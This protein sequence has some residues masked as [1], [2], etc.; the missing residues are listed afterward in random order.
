MSLEY[1]SN[2]RLSRYNLQFHGIYL[3]AEANHVLQPVAVFEYQATEVQLFF[4]TM[5]PYGSLFRTKLS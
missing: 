5:S 2:C 3:V 1:L 4:S